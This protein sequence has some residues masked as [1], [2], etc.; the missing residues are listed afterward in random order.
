MRFPANPI[1]PLQAVQLLESVRRGRQGTRNCAALT[2]LYRTG[3]RVAELC[4]LRLEDVYWGEDE[5]QRVGYL[6]VEKPKGIER[7]SAPRE[8]GLDPK[9]V[10]ILDEWLEVRG[11]APGPLFHTRQINELQT[12]Y[13]RQL[14]PR[15][16]LKCGLTRRVHAHAFRHAFARG[17]WDDTH[18]LIIVMLALGHSDARTTM[19][20]LRSI[21]ATEVIAATTRREW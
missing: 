18:D 6:R 14:L 21:G 5:G 20:Y 17:L 8:V 11:A 9:T 15:H 13:F 3:L 7:Y 1:T 19:R 10:K 4:S 12:S 16:A 2:L